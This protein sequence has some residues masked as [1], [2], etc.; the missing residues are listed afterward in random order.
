M[1]DQTPAEVLPSLYR[2]VLD[3]VARLERA[4]QREVAWEIRRKAL[5]AYSTR[6][7]AHGR[8]AL[9]RLGRDA[10]TALAASPPAAG[11]A[12]L[13]TGTEPA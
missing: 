9:Q 1:D 6:W 12:A 3:A 8:R 11:A 4:G 5:I 7:D 13:A 10:R 2:E